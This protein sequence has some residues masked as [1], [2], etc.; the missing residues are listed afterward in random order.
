MRARRDDDDTECV[1]RKKR[2]NNIH[3]GD[4]GRLLGRLGRRLGR[5]DGGEGELGRER[6]GEHG[7]F[8]EL[9]CYC[10]V[11]DSIHSITHTHT[12]TRRFEFR[13]PWVPFFLFGAASV[14]G[15]SRVW[16]N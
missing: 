2:R 14:S 12:R 6:R 3:L 15:V 16:V 5:D 13:C 10:G 1:R 7:S 4:D 9:E 8:V 11:R